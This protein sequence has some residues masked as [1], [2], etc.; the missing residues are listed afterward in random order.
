VGDAIDPVP[1]PA[2]L[3]TMRLSCDGAVMIGFPSAAS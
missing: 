3:P 1:S 2:P